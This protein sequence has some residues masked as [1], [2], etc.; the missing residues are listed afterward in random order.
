M[1]DDLRI[2]QIHAIIWQNGSGGKEWYLG[3][4]KEKIENNFIVDH[5]HRISKDSDL[6]WTYPTT[7]DIQTVEREQILHIEIKGDW[8]ME[9]NNKFVLKNIKEVNIEFKKDT[10]ETHV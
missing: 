8:N 3:Y 4:I 10:M 9:R 5:L 7:P 2:N 1:W 6:M